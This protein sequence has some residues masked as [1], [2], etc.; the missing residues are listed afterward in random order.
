MGVGKEAVEYALEVLQQFYESVA[1]PQ[2]NYV[3][4]NSDREGN[5]V[6]DL[7][8]EVFDAQYHGSQ[9]ESKGIVGILE[10]IQ[11]DFDRTIAKTEKE[12]K[13]SQE[14]FEKFEEDT[15]TDI[16]DKT[17]PIL[18]PVNLSI[19][20]GQLPDFGSVE[21]DTKDQERPSKTRG[22]IDIAK[23]KKI[24]KK[25]NTWA[26]MSSSSVSVSLARGVPE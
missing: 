4:P 5:T 19:L 24:N 10:V 23:E 2:L 9:A 8:P 20:G 16:D 17:E 25:L 21:P 11:S 1:L 18:E 6:G 15:N 13:A 22:Q 12:E 3:P 14:A 26:E 7:A